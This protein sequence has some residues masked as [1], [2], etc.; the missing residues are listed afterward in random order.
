MVSRKRKRAAVYTTPETRSKKQ[1]NKIFVRSLPY[2][3]QVPML[4][5]IP[6][7][8]RD[9]A[10]LRE[11]I[12]NH[13]GK[14]V[15]TFE[16]YVYQLKNKRSRL[17]RKKVYHKGYVYDES[18]IQDCIDEGSLEDIEDYQI[19]F[20]KKSDL[21]TIPKSTR[22][23]YTITE[24]LRLWDLIEAEGEKGCPPVKFFQKIAL[25]NLI[26][27][28]SAQSLRTAWKK[29]SSMK[30]KN[31]VKGALKKKGTRFSHIYEETPEISSKEESK[32]NYSCS[33]NLNKRFN[34]TSTKYEEEDD[35]STP[36]TPMVDLDVMTKEPTFVDNQDDD[37]EFVLEI[38]DMQSVLSNNLTKDQSYSTKY[39]KRRNKHSLDEM[40]EEF[41]TKSNY[42]R[43]KVTESDTNGNE[44]IESATTIYDQM[45][46]D[47][48]LNSPD[49]KVVIHHN[50]SEGTRSVESTIPK[51]ASN[52]DET[53]FKIISTQLEEL[54]EIY[55]KS[56]EEMHTIYMEA[57][58]DMDDLRK[59]LSGEKER[60]TALEDLAVQ[61]EP[62][63]Q[64]FDLV[65]HNRGQDEI[66]KRKKFFELQ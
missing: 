16:A 18:Y 51:G 6:P 37:M 48:F 63:S 42:K 61:S 39:R 40:Y 25:E 3:G 8:A 19:G 52:E 65:R 43:V 58:C 26:P 29:F 60:W 9:F 64:E 20:N 38:E 13:G 21:Y 34:T 55:G 10:K 11:K 59:S 41:A 23:Q 49:A 33:K 35:M 47:N 62:G 44:Y 1:S 7:S 12:E 66:L 53:Y 32:D 45:D 5:Y 14:V 30:K 4:F 2:I 36:S 17:P 50:P 31:F 54:C 57:N 24:V 27:D 56:M 46:L 28:R 15:D 22:R